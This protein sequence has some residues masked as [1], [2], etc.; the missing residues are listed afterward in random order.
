[1]PCENSLKN[2]RPNSFRIVRATASRNLVVFLGY[3]LL[4]VIQ[5]YPLVL[6][7][8]THIPIFQEASGWVTDERDPWHSLW[9]LWYTHYSVVELGRLPFS[10]DL[11]FSP[12][13]VGLMYV[14]FIIISLLCALP[15][16]SLVGLI[17]TYN[18]LIL[19]SLAGS[20]Y[21]T[22]LLVN[23]LTQ[24]SRAAF[25][26]G[27][28]FAFS[29]FHMVRSLEQLFM[30]MSAVWLPL[31]V[32]F[33]CKGMRS[34]N[35]IH[36]FLAAVF[37]LLSLLSNPYYAMFLILF[38]GLFLV[39]HLW[40]PEPLGSRSALIRRGAVMIGCTGLCL[41]PLAVIVLLREW[42][43]ILL[44]RP[45]SESILLSADLL[46]FF[47]PSPYHP[48]WGSLARP[49][50]ERFTGNVFEQTVYLGYTTLA[51]SGVALLKGP[52]QE[53]RFWRCAALSFFVL[54]LGPFL[55][56]GG[57]YLLTIDGMPVTFPL[58]ALLFHF[59][60]VLGAARAPSRFAI[61]LM[62]CLAV[63]VG[64]GMKLLVSPL[65]RRQRAAWLGR[66]AF[67]MLAAAMLCE[68]LSLPMP[69]IDAR[70]P[71]LYDDI[72][73]AG[74]RT[75]SLVD[76]PL[77]WSLAR[78]QYY[79][80]A[81]RKPL[82]TG[83][84]PR[85]HPWLET[86]GDV[87][88]LMQVFKDPVGVLRREQSWEQNEAGRLID[89]FDLD[90]IVLHRD[91]LPADF[92]EPFTQFLRDTFPVQ[93]VVEAGE[94]TVLWMSRDGEQ[95]RA[96]RPGDYQWDFSPQQ[97]SPFLSEGWSPCE[98]WGELTL[99]WSNAR[100]SRLWVFFPRREDIVMD[101]RVLPVNLVGLPPQA[102]T[103]YLN[104]QFVREIQLDPGVWQ[105][106]ALT[107]PQAHVTTG[108]NHIS[109]VYRYTARPADVVADDVDRRPLAVAF[110]FIRFRVE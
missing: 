73:Q 38:S 83:F 14:S 68:F 90:V 67:W 109:F 95:R 27:L 62:L 66:A 72:R 33:L 49:L 52:R 91:Y 46:A 4:A 9:L 29:P 37:F 100:A 87:F 80:T 64:Y 19:G 85:P 77:H 55:H 18:L 44:Y 96:W 61:M 78:F 12:K 81:H 53:I 34:G 40:Q 51:L 94:M 24:N 35:T 84:S 39:Y 82:L 31:Y 25:L 97:P 57:T 101:L 104:Q 11:L 16:I 89:R 28:V 15:L 60:P 1:M 88:P 2:V 69:T 75:G 47:T 41:L 6:Q 86:Y 105:S 30:V 92:V 10:T 13:G 99:A 50:Y 17:A 23:Y 48:L 93:R 5:T 106:H 21:A 58:P 110:D 45:F 63:L 20:G 108:V 42:P 103:I 71:Q 56:V 65:E 102:M 74:K 79:Q 32:L 54:T 26:A 8:G 7:L 22:F 98:R 43:D 76:V 36:L 59:F 70:I 3:L 107:L